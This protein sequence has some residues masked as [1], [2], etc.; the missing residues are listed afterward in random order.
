[1]ARCSPGQGSNTLPSHHQTDSPSGPY[2][3]RKAQPGTPTNEN[4]H[5]RP[6]ERAL[7]PAIRSDS[8]NARRASQE[9]RQHSTE[10]SVARTF[11]VRWEDGGWGGVRGGGSPFP[12][13][14]VCPVCNREGRGT[15]GVRD[16]AMP[17]AGSRRGQIAAGRT[18]FGRPA[19]RLS[20]FLLIVLRRARASHSARVFVLPPGSGGSVR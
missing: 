17:S 13:R 11:P 3:A 10:V 18:A 14:P 7:A 6:Q 19:P 2:P 5:Q 9:S 4:A 16:Q 12:R 15:R 1:M 20:T 8:R